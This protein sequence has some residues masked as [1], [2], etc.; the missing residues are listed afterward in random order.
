MP[1]PQLSPKYQRSWKSR[2]VGSPET[3]KKTKKHKG[4]AF[5]L[6]LFGILFL[7]GVV[8]VIG[9][10]AWISRDL[11]DPDKILERNIAQSTQIFDRTGEHLLYEIYGDKK[12]TLVTLKD[13]PDYLEQATISMEDKNFYKHGGVSLWGIFRGVVLQKLRGGSAQG[14]STLTQQ[15]VKN[16]ILTDERTVTRK[17]KEWILSYQIENKFSKDE[18]LQMYLNEIPYGSTAYGVQTASQKYFGK[19]VQDINL[20]EAAILAALPQAPTRYSPYGSNKDILIGRQQYILD[21]MVEQG[22]IT[23]TQAEEAKNTE[24]V[25]VSQSTDIEA[26]HFVMYVKELL[27]EKYGERVVEEGGLKVITTLDYD[28][29]KIAE[30]IIAEQ[31]PKN[32][33]RYNAE[34]AALVAIDTKTG[35]ILTMVGSRN[36]FDENIDGQVNIA[37]RGN[38]PGSSFKPIAY[39]TAFERGYTPE[40]MLFDLKTDFG[41]YSPSNYDGGE[42]GPVSMRKALA[43]SLNIPAVKTLYLAGVNNVI[44]TAHD[45]GYT[46]LNDPDRYGLS[47]VLGGG[48]VKLLEHVSAYSTLARE[49]VRHPHTAIMKVEDRDGK[50][51][52]EFTESEGTEVIDKNAV[53]QL[54]SIL[55]DNDARAYIFGASNYLTLPDR[56]V[57]TKTGTTN[58]YKDAWTMGYTPSIAAGVWVGNNDNSEMSHG[59]DGSIVAAPI[60]NQFMKRVLV[61]SPVET[62]NAPA[63]NDSKKPILRGEIDTVTTRVVDIY[64]GKTIPQSC[65]DSYPSKYTK[66]V[67]YKE[68]HTILHYVDKNDPD[69]PIPSNPTSDPQYNQWEAPVRAW[70]Q[71]NGYVSAGQEVFEDCNF[72]PSD[73]QPT[74]TIKKPA[75]DAELNEETFSVSAQFSAKDNHEITKVEYYI[76]KT[77]VETVTNTP[78]QTTYSAF[79]LTNGKHTLTVVA[80][81]EVANSSQESV[82]FTY[83]SNLSAT[84]Y[85][86][87]PSANDIFNQNN[88]PLSINSYSYSPEGIEKISLYYSQPGVSSPTL[89]NS[90]T[91]PG[92][93]SNTIQWQDYPETGS[94]NLYISVTTRNNKRATS[95]LLPLVIE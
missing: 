64:S 53:R 28:K 76:D 41:D 88:F 40:T 1:I 55:T 93:N 94:Y 18:I 86:V 24:L 39:V 6:R 9:M 25:F 46:T 49:G 91:N 42:R 95:D 77:L 54:N 78:F 44:D 36:Y 27:T 30:E 48:D 57:A 83:S 17:I 51:L 32:E 16:S 71:R 70:A 23:E 75:K 47:L 13:I 7:A 12:R 59:A 81:D 60:W 68:T 73:Q 62:F 80:Y 15:F 10:F 87:S 3:G 82:N 38:Q 89:I 19:N 45:L 21:L 58:D 74:V 14:G 65:I 90:I 69:G 37:I 92:S 34:N 56:P 31:V 11:P 84:V 61:G 63:P 35:Q 50:V 33:A 67:S 8:V 26:P 20:A 79:N 43:G 4:K 29:Q 22:Y 72:R 66:E 85:F 5:Y 2:P 52:E